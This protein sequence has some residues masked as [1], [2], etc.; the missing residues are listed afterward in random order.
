MTEVLEST[1]NEPALLLLKSPVKVTMKDSPLKKLKEQTILMTLVPSGSQ[2]LT[3]VPKIDQV[4]TLDLKPDQK[5][6]LEPQI[7]TS[8]KVPILVPQVQ[9]PVKSDL[10]LTKSKEREKIL[11]Q[12]QKIIPK[13]YKLGQVPQLRDSPMS[14]EAH[15]SKE[16]S[17]LKP[18]HSV[19]QKNLSDAEPGPVI[20]KSLHTVQ[21]KSVIETSV[22]DKSSYKGS[23][24]VHSDVSLML[25]SAEKLGP[26]FSN[27]SPDKDTSFEAITKTIKLSKPLT[28]KESLTYLHP[29]VNILPQK[30]SVPLSTEQQ[31]EKMV[32]DTQSNLPSTTPLTDKF[33]PFASLPSREPLTV[34]SSK[35]DRKSQNIISDSIA[36]KRPNESTES[37]AASRYPPLMK[38]KQLP[39]SII[40]DFKDEDSPFK[41]SRKST[42]KDWVPASPGKQLPASKEEKLPL[43]KNSPLNTIF[44]NAVRRAQNLL[45]PAK[46]KSLS[47]NQDDKAV[48]ET[49]SVKRVVT[50]KNSR[51]NLMERLTADTESSIARSVRKVDLQPLKQIHNEMESPLSKRFNQSP[52]SRKFTADKKELVK[53][54]PAPKLTDIPKIPVFKPKAMSPVRTQTTQPTKRRVDSF[55]PEKIITKQELT[56]SSAG[57]A[58]STAVESQKKKMRPQESLT[59]FSLSNTL[60]QKRTSN[61]AQQRMNKSMAE[62]RKR[63]EELRKQRLSNVQN[64]RMKISIDQQIANPLQKMREKSMKATE[65][66]IQDVEV[67]NGQKQAKRKTETEIKQTERVSTVLVPLSDENM[68]KRRKTEEKKLDQKASR[69]T[70]EKISTTSTSARTKTLMRSAMIQRARFNSTASTT[71]S[72]S[73]ASHLTPAEKSRFSV[74]TPRSPVQLPEIYSDPEDDEEGHVLKDWAQSPELKKLLLK[75]QN[76][77]PDVV[78]GAI[79]PLDMDQIFSK[80]RAAKF[81]ARSSSAHWGAQDM[82]SHKEADEYTKKMGWKI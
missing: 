78:F 71:K 21:E 74:S 4:P 9:I 82:L 40:H 30:E 50:S 5:L 32:K 33:T 23:S 36:E 17:Q 10:T 16:V 81:R 75:Q 67:E 80:S 18:V 13:P 47:R 3:L 28:S 35:K 53:M 41:V 48:V 63:V 20:T 6:T 61:I 73:R 79:A 15:S 2:N 69:L 22:E 19:L 11:E 29:S 31:K 45:S 70:T 59:G 66:L 1:E 38:M 60:A 72:A 46:E 39:K 58:A 65:N 54:A 77:N 43:S 57:S 14:S 56:K 68:N 26:V 37:N 44:A 76:V 24:N 51:G 55:S 27:A 12:V 64:V 49:K 8:V 34:Q 62:E 42:G 25:R 7:L 52:L